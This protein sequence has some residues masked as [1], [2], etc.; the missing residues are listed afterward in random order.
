MILIEEEVYAVAGG[1]PDDG[2][3]YTFSYW[4]QRDI[5]ESESRA[6][7]AKFPECKTIVTKRPLFYFK[8]GNE[9]KTYFYVPTIKKVIV[10]PP[11]RQSILDKMT[12]DEI[13]I[14][15]IKP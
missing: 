9:P 8:T 3:S 11:T 6:I 12:P 1:H 15:G 5:A 13:E 10:N 7:N 2:T 4:H 14:L